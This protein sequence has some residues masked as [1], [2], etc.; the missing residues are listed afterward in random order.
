MTIFSVRKYGA[1]AA[2]VTSLSV[3]V[4]IAAQPATAADFT[5]S[6]RFADTVN[7]GNNPDLLN[8][9]GGSFDGTY[10]TN[11]LPMSA[12][13][14]ATISSW[15]FNLRNSIGTL[16]KVFSSDT[17][18]YGAGG[19]SNGVTDYLAF[20]NNAGYLRLEFASGFTGTGPIRVNLPSETGMFSKIV[21]QEVFR[22]F[23]DEIPIYGQTELDIVSGSSQS[24]PTPALLPGL[25]G[26]GVAAFRRRRGEVQPAAD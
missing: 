21:T 3:L 25:V 4:T 9:T 7:F 26:M 24:V 20:G 6:G 11:D 22:D 18:G 16:L 19:G 8:L 13:G 14:A 12:G 2:T 1:I 17:P 5:A 15:R 10:S 23:N